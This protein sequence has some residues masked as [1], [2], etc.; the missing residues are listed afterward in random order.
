MPTAQQHLFRA[1]LQRRVQQQHG[2]TYHCKPSQNETCSTTTSSHAF[3]LAL[4]LL[5]TAQPSSLHALHRAAHCRR[6][7]LH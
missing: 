6:N 1:F 2:E 5:R 7:A 4:T 3:L